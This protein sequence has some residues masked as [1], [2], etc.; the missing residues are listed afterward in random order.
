[1]TICR[2]KVQTFLHTLCR[3]NLYHLPS[4]LT[5]IKLLYEVYIHGSLNE[6]SNHD[7]NHMKGKGKHVSDVAW[8]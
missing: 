5:E 6:P 7:G 2:F 3:K 1:M 4:V 8:A